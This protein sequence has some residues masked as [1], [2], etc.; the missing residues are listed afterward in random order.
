MSRIDKIKAEL[1]F[2]TSATY[3]SGG[4][5]VR[6]Y[7]DAWVAD[8]A[9]AGGNTN[10]LVNAAIAWAFMRQLTHKH[11]GQMMLHGPGGAVVELPI[12]AQPFVSQESDVYR[13]PLLIH[14]NSKYLQWMQRERGMTTETAVHDGFRLLGAAGLHPEMDIRISVGGETPVLGLG[15]PTFLP[16]LLPLPPNLL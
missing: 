12:L 1:D 15:A 4:L 16:K 2:V 5:F 3:P 11:S 7:V 6:D 14:E 9:E 8:F 13:Q 10:D